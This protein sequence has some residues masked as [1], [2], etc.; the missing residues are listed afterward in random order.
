[1][2]VSY[3]VSSYNKR[4]W[5]PAV[6]ASVA[7]ERGKTG[8]EIVLIDD[9]SADGSADLCAAFAAGTPTCA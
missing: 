9:G 5:L 1:M 7:R 4:P 2:P 6:L 3:L 8:G